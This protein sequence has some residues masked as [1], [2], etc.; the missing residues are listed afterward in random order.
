M[1]ICKTCKKEKELS[2]FHKN[3]LQSDGHMIH[4]ADCANKKK[5]E[6]VVVPETKQC[7]KCKRYKQLK[8]YSLKFGDKSGYNSQ[9]KQCA[10]LY[11]KNRK[12]AKAKPQRPHKEGQKQCAGCME[13]KDYCA[14][15]RSRSSTDGYVHKCKACYTTSKK[16][17]MEINYAA[18]YY[19]VALD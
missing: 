14:F 11:Q 5:R 10:S 6:R 4:C 7:T 16:A 17:N 9:C 1:K 18:F 12:A 15:P 2:Q 8:E 13:M 19:P 3:R